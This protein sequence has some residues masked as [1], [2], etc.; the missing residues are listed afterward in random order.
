MINEMLVW[1]DKLI[2]KPLPLDPHMSKDVLVQ[3]SKECLLEGK[4]ILACVNNPPKK[5][6]IKGMTEPLGSQ[7][8]GHES[9][10]PRV[11][12]VRTFRSAI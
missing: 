2:T 9:R 4:Q 1:W 5:P 7:R 12:M 8:V 10:R 6:A 3:Y 11:T